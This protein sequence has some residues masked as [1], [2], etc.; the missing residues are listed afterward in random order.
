M[1]QIVIVLMMLV[2]CRPTNGTCLRMGDDYPSCRA[3]VRKSGCTAARYKPR[4]FDESRAAG[5]AR[6]HLLG[7]TH[8]FTNEPDFDIFYPP[9]EEVRYPEMPELPEIRIDGYGST[10]TE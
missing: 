9:R 6:C 5:R 2:G 4:F 7:Y 10:R 3:N 1:K 8:Q